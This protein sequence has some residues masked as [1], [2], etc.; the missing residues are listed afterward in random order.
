MMR[1]KSRNK[2]KLLMIT[3]QFAAGRV[4][5]WQLRAGNGKLMASGRYYGQKSKAKRAAWIVRWLF[6]IY[7]RELDP[8]RVL[9][10]EAGEKEAD[11]GKN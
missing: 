8:Y 4:H 7:G 5:S 2:P 9:G 6:R 11:N 1:K 10:K 3:G